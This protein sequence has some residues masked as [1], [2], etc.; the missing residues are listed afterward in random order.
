M[1][2]LLGSVLI[3][4]SRPFLKNLHPVLHSGCYLFTSSVGGF[5]FSTLSPA[6][7]VNFW[8]MVLVKHVRKCLTVVLICMSLLFSKVDIFSCVSFKGCEL[9]LY[10][11]IG[12]LNACPVL[13]FFSVTPRTFLESR[14]FL[15]TAP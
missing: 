9:N 1:C 6:F 14:Y 5:P 11:E 10:L 12:H 2:M 15:L 8:T 13:D 7:I 3:S 4:F